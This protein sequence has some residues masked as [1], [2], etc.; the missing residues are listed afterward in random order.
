M[1]RR[2]AVPLHHLHYTIDRLFN[3]QAHRDRLHEW[4]SSTDPALRAK[5]ERD[6]RRAEP[7]ILAYLEEIWADYSG[8][9]IHLWHLP[10]LEDYSL[11]EISELL[12]GE[13]VDI[14]GSV[15]LRKPDDYECRIKSVARQSDGLRVVVVLREV[16]EIEI[17][18]EPE[19]LPVTK[20]VNMLFD[21]T[22][23][24]PLVEVYAGRTHA[25]KALFYALEQIVGDRLPRRGRISGMV[26]I[27]FDQ[28][29]AWQLARQLRMSEYRYQ[30]SD[31]HAELGDVMHGMGRNGDRR[32]P[33]NMSIERVRLQHP[34]PK[35]WREFFFDH[36]H[37]DG[38]VEYSELRFTFRDG[39][40]SRTPHLTFITRTSRPAVRSV[41]TA[42]RD[43]VV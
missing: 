5:F 40:S 23:A 38:F 11:D 41:V 43:L 18:E 1:A 25:R 20:T 29:H 32:L 37:D 35:G 16:R 10:M 24:A 9:A 33:L 31:V 27:E 3:S 42:L 8:H 19:E 13:H 21:E 28:T 12:V 6:L 22:G 36:Q 26:P 17:D 14:G 4:A 15:T 30:G 34:G 7:G 39:T 2:R